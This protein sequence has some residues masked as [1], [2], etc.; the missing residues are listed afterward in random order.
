MH[1]GNANAADELGRVPTST[2]GTLRIGF[3][4]FDDKPS[5]HRAGEPFAALVA[6]VDP[7]APVAAPGGLKTQTIGPNSEAIL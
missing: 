7:F 2:H 4:F 1:S 5:C 3:P 6:A